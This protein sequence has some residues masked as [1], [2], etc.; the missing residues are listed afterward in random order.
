ME[1]IRSGSPVMVHL[2]KLT[3]KDKND[4]YI[5]RPFSNKIEITAPK[6]TFAIKN[7]FSKCDRISR[8]FQIWSHTLKKPK[9]EKCIFCGVISLGFDLFCQEYLHDL[10]KNF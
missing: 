2:L 9:M 10:V 1:G 5:S 6:M 4:K 7:L 8:K 3:K